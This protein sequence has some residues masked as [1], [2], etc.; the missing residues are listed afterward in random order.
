MWLIGLRTQHRV[1]EDVGLIPGLDQWV[2]DPVLPC[3]FLDDSKMR[4]AEVLGAWPGLV[5]STQYTPDGLHGLNE[6]LFTGMLQRH[7]ILT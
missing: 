5:T 7:V 6:S 3:V 2:K 1:H 4:W